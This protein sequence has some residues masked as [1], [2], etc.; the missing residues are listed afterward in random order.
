MSDKA[1]QEATKGDSHFCSS[2]VSSCQRSMLGWIKTMAFW[3]DGGQIFPHISVAK[4]CE[5]GYK[6]YFF[7]RAVLRKLFDIRF[8]YKHCNFSG[9]CLLVKMASKTVTRS[10][11]R[12]ILECF[13]CVS[14]RDRKMTIHHGCN[15]MQL[16]I[17]YPFRQRRKSFQLNNSL[18]G[19]KNRL[20]TKILFNFAL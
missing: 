9:V 14:W 6:S 8:S 18:T 7:R 13:G 10:I 2:M 17:T 1:S 3:S 11:S 20:K 12:Q 15:L 19:Y 4:A 16:T 5:L